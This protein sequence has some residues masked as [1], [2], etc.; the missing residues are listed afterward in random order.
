MRISVEIGKV[1]GKCRTADVFEYGDNA[2]V[3]IFKPEF[4]NSQADKEQNLHTIVQNFGLPVPKLYDVIAYEGRKG[5]VYQK[6]NGVTMLNLINEN[7]NRMPEYAKDMASLHI[8][9]GLCK[10]DCEMES[11][12]KKYASWIN[13]IDIFTDDEKKV[14]NGYL[15]GL[16]EKD[17]LCHGDF[18]PDN[19][20]VDNG[21]YYII[22][23]LTATKGSFCADVMRSYMLIKYGSSADDVDITPEIRIGIDMFTKAYMDCLIESREVNLDDVFKWELPTLAARLWEGV[24]KSEKTVVLER[25]HQ[26]L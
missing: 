20:L 16:E 23:W 11:I 25:L 1:I 2:I 24:P 15:D 17:K 13:N 12:N 9:I 18:H 10:I 3:K 26:L 8:D 5:L 14:I 6:I 21:K 19:I 7:P 22:D 4:S